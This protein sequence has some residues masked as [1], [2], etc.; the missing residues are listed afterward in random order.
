MTLELKI[1]PQSICDVCEYENSLHA[2]FC[3]DCGEKLFKYQVVEPQPTTAKPNK[4]FYSNHIYAGFLKR[5]VALLVDCSVLLLGCYLLFLAMA[6]TSLAE[7]FNNL[8]TSAYFY[9]ACCLYF[10]LMDSRIFQGTLGKHLLGIHVCDHQGKPLSLLHA[11]FRQACMLISVLTGG[12]A[13]LL[14]LFSEHNQ[15]LHDYLADTLVVNSSTSSSQIKLVN[16]QR[17]SLTRHSILLLG[18]LAFGIL[19]ACLF[20]QQIFGGTIF[21]PT[22][23]KPAKTATTK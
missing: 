8:F 11:L 9:L 12:I 3:S 17:I 5:L 7:Y 22:E 13:Y 10:I 15:S 23:P 18:L 19:I 6:T 1:K 4:L 21:F 20:R 14:I 2:K 16:Q